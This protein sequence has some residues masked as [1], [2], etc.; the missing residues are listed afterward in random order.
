MTTG[1]GDTS[2]PGPYRKLR[3]DM[4]IHESSS[5]LVAT[6]ES[7][8]KG[9]ISATEL[10]TRCQACRQ[11]VLGSYMTWA[12]ESAAA[13]AA[14]ADAAFQAGSCTGPLQG[15]PMSV[16]DL[17][18]V[19]GLP[20]YAGSLHPL[21][22]KWQQEGPIVRR[23]RAQLGVIVGKTH[24]VEF[25]F[26]GLGTN[27]H[28][29]APR[30]V[31]DQTRVPGGSSS[32]AAVSVAEG[33]AMLAIGTDTSGSIRVPACMNGLAGLKITKGRWPTDGIVP[34]SPSLDTPGLIARSTGD[35]AYAFTSLDQASAKIT[36]ASSIPESCVSLTFGVPDS[37]FWSDCSPGIVEEIEEVL[38]RLE[39]AGAGIKRV[40]LPGCEEADEIF[41]NGGLAAPE[42]DR[43][44][45]DELPEWRMSLD[46][47]VEARIQSAESLSA[48]EYLQRQN[49]L[50]EL[51][52]SAVAASRQ[53]DA[54]IT[55]TVAITPPR[56]DEIDDPATYRT[57]NLLALRNTAVVN[58]LDLCALTIPVGSDA[59][60]MPVGLQLITGP[61]REEYLLSV[62]RIVSSVAHE[63]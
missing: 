13:Q 61:W 15:I 25:A 22:N 37:F 50:Q 10:L 21:P 40:H 53:V 4:E 1:N 42:L 20:V 56:F 58:L 8:R 54:L 30:N 32:G 24:T 11:E 7:L 59:A 36:N 9:L 5:S 60:G 16:K 38:R 33:S 45:A 31:H 43:F 48:R 49:R 23:I 46:P 14:A 3:E 44:L 52:R 63:S 51:A 47:A 19:S 39:T 35:L 17:F 29:G 55:P 2:T 57:F 6:C 41:R 12:P 34:L 27:T 18:G 26:G 28:W 62:G